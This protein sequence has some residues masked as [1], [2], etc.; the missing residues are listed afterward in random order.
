MRA[1][2][3]ALAL[4]AAASLSGCAAIAAPVLIA[5]AIGGHHI[6]YSGD[7]HRPD[8]TTAP[9]IPQPVP[10]VAYAAPIPATPLPGPVAQPAAAAPA[11]AEQ[12]PAPGLVPAA[13][14]VP[15]G[16]QFLY[17]SGEA[18]AL[19]VQAYQGLIDLMVARSSDHAVGMKV[20]SVVIQPGSTLAA[21]KFVPCDNKPLAVVL[22][23]DETAIQNLGYESY[24]SAHPDSYDRS[25][26]DR[27]EGS[28]NQA[29]K[30][31]P[32]MLAAVQAAQKAKVTLVYNS[33]RL[34]SHAAQTIAVLNAA[35]LGPVQHL[36]TLWLRGDAGSKSDDKD[37]RRWAISQQYC[38]IAMV[39]DQLG[40][41]SDLFNAPNLTLEARREAVSNENLRIMW[42]RGWFILPNPVYGT[43]L[44]GD[45]DA[46]FPPAARWNDPGAKAAP[47]TIT[48]PDT[49]PT[50]NVSSATH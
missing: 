29:V 10:A 1:A 33:N 31:T 44:K 37:S 46:I 48:A 2:A 34:T 32:G 8:P 39:G 12:A 21:P 30:A 13:Y 19:S 16:M 35:G 40:D 42:G 28:A 9:A 26:W 45:Y 15:G 20:W 6:I 47:P 27:W 36:K 11:I 4:G 41:F 5:G 38:V 24:D 50:S 3:L 23:I 43:A 22:D 18:A 17:G 25:R 14:Q 49:E 7:D